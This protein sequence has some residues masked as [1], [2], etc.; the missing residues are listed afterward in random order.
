MGLERIEIGA[1]CGIQNL[2]QLV[3]NGN[4]LTSLPHLYSMKCCLENLE[5]AS[6]NISR[7]S[8]HFFKGFKKLKVINLIDNN[9]LELP[10][11]HWVQHSVF[12][13]MAKGNKIES[14][15]ALQTP[16][17]YT[18]L[19]VI[20]M[21]KNDIHNFN[22]SIL[23]HIPKLR[24][25]D[26]S[27]NILTHI[28]D[29]RGPHERFI[30]LNGNPWH[31]NAELSWMGEE[32]M[33]FERGLTCATPTCLHGMA[34][35]DMSKL[36]FFHTIYLSLSQRARFLCPTWGPPGSWWPQVGPTLAPWILLSG[37]FLKQNCSPL[38]ELEH[39]R[40]EQF[41][42]GTIEQSHESHNALVPYHTMH[43]FWAKMCTFLLQSG[44]LRGMGHVHCGIC[45]IRLFAGFGAIT[46][47][48]K[49]FCV[50]AQPMRDG[51]HGNA[52]SHWLG[53]YTEL[54][55][56]THQEKQQTYLMSKTANYATQNF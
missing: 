22:V 40:S 26:L 8:K 11:L 15:Y 44:A 24:N 16:G 52:V 36:I 51:L 47:E 13:L 50:C 21:Y 4:K 7:L 10:D 5:V 27:Y 1:F 3:L 45:E 9:L 46:K 35:S 25:F 39:E 54:S 48:L 37:M 19:E 43:Y 30:N 56:K 53:V 23:R 28:D 20:V 18:R 31:C 38:S 17:R 6:N 29:F 12:N 32:D 33:F 2:S 34:I 49:S 55:L 42:L 41:C 14:L